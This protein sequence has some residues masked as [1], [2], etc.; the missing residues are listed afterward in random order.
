MRAWQGHLAG[1]VFPPGN[2]KPAV[3]SHCDTNPSLSLSLSFREKL[4]MLAGLVLQGHGGKRYR[5]LLHN[6]AP[7]S[8]AANLFL[9]VQNLAEKEHFKN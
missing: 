3:E 6:P 2:A 1:V 7:G 4:V 5:V 8:V 9:H